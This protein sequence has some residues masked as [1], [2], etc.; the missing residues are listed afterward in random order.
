MRELVT[1]D[2]FSQSTYIV[3]HDQFEQAMLTVSPANTLVI[4]A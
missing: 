2:I 4:Q 1:F 3:A